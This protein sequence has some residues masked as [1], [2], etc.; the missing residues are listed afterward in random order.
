MRRDTKVTVTLSQS[1]HVLIQKACKPT[2]IL[3]AQFVRNAALRAAE[4]ALEAPTLNTVSPRFERTP[5]GTIN[6]CALANHGDERSCQI[7]RG[8]CPDRQRF[9]HVDGTAQC[10]ACVNQFQTGRAV[11]GHICGYPVDPRTGLVTF[12]VGAS[13]CSA[14]LE[15]ARTGMTQQVHVCGR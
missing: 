4:L 8:Q 13:T 2:G 12:T 15:I 6:N 10:A 9:A 5:N 11:A 7:C 1:E 3:V 14:C